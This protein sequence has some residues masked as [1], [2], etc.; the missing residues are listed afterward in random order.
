LPEIK[1]GVTARVDVLVAE[2]DDVIKIPLQAVVGIEERQFCFVRNESGSQPVEVELGLF[3]SEF[4]QVRSG[5]EAG[6]EVALSPPATT[7]IPE[8]ARLRPDEPPVAPDTVVLS[9]A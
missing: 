1:P 7:R 9:E 5:L 4:V 3:D 6:D 2:L 8:D